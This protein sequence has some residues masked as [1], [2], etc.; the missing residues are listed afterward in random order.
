[1]PE[2]PEVETIKRDLE[3]NIIN[4]VVKKIKI[5]SSKNFIGEPYQIINQKIIKLERVGKHLIFYLSNKKYLNVHFKMTGEFLYADNINQA[6]F[7]N[8]I[9]FANVNKMPAKT[10]RVI[11]KFNDQSG[12]FFNDLRKFGWLMISN[13]PFLPKGIDVLSKSFTFEKFNQ[14]ISDSRKPIKLLLLDQEKLAGIGNIYAN[15]SLFLSRVNPFKRAQTLDKKMR[16][17]LYQSIKKVINQAIDHQGSTG[18]DKAFIK[19][20]GSIGQHQNYFL[21]Y[22]REGQSCFR[23]RSLIKRVKQNGRST[24]FCSKCQV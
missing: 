14:L 20:D 8:K 3:K 12:L 18:A 16:Q 13:Q 19:P 22:Q 7:K 6:V 2:L 21:V 9:P 11:I 1:M 5:L 10:T 4:K 17:R 23:C 15:E 24:F